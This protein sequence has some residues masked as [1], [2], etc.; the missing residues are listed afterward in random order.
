MRPRFFVGVLIFALSVP[1]TVW[2]SHRYTDVAVTS[3]FHDGISWAVANRLLSG[4]GGGKFCP[5]GAL[6]RDHAARALARLGQPLQAA[7][8]ESAAARPRTSQGGLREASVATSSGIDKKS[9]VIA[10]TSLWA[11]RSGGA[12]SVAAG[13]VPAPQ[14]AAS[15]GTHGTIALELD[16]GGLCDGTSE[17]N[18]AT[19]DSRGV[20]WSAQVSAAAP[21]AAGRHRIDLCLWGSD[22]TGEPEVGL[23]AGN[24]TTTWTPVAGKITPSTTQSGG[25]STAATSDSNALSPSQQFRALVETRAA[26]DR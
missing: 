15:S 14:D 25:F 13:L 9:V 17:L 24:V 19:W 18:F 23:I 1:A 3:P 11:P 7:D 20:P 8:V 2:A 6:R 4:C 10:T 26:G 22:A 16:N 5:D 21:V 12:L